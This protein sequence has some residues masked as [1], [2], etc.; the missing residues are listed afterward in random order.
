MVKKMLR[1]HWRRTQE[2]MLSKVIFFPACSIINSKPTHSHHR[3]TYT[4][5]DLLTLYR[6]RVACTHIVCHVMLYC[7]VGMLDV[8]LVA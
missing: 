1:G 2:A 4:Y 6:I 8:A 3:I 7:I 5:V